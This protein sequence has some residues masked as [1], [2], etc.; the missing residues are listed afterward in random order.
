M[1]QNDAS[2]FIDIDKQYYKD[3][4]GIDST[5]PCYYKIAFISDGSGFITRGHLFCTSSYFLNVVDVAPENQEENT[6]Y[7]VKE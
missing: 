1:L 3:L 7:L 2:L 6:I 4:I 5:H